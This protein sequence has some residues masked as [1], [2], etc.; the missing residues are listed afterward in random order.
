MCAAFASPDVQAISEIAAMPGVDLVF[1]KGAN[2]VHMA[3]RIH[4][5][6]AEK[7]AN[8][9]LQGRWGVNKGCACDG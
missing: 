8:R 3:E 4:A 6:L 7:E 1:E 5:V 9:R 2:M